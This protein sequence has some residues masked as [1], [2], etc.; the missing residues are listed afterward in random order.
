[1]NEQLK[2]QEDNT[3]G[4]APPTK[5]KVRG[6]K[7]K[8]G[9]KTSARHPQETTPLLPKISTPPTLPAQ[10]KE[11]LSTKL[12]WREKEPPMSASP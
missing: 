7:N 1:M 12:M 4:P 8:K 10:K 3:K 9:G 2:E 5:K 11:N 6:K